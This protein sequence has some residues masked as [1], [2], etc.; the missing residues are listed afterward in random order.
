V[1]GLLGTACV[2]LNPK[3]GQSGNSAPAH[4]RITKDARA[5]V[6]GVLAEAAWSASRAPGPLR[7]SCQRIMARRGFQT[8][9]AAAARKLTVLAWHLV[10]KDQD[11]ASARPALVAHKRRK[12]ELAAD[13]PSRRGNH[14]QPA[15]GL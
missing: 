5:Q 3:A 6:R 1:P 13:A 4:G 12:L 11:Y 7:A 10:T 14:R 2:G 8:A 15:A 9:V